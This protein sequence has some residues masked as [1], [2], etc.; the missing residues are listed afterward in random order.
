MKGPIQPFHLSFLSYEKK[1]TKTT[2]GM[3]DLVLTVYFTLCEK[4]TPILILT[5][6]MRRMRFSISMGIKCKTDFMWRDTA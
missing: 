4:K 3:H 5:R 2:R 1:G 6:E